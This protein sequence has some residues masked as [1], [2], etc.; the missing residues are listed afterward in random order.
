MKNYL[1]YLQSGGNTRNLK[2][3]FTKKPENEVAASDKETSSYI[4]WNIRKLLEKYGNKKTDVKTSEVTPAPTISN[5]SGRVVNL[6]ISP[7]HPRDAYTYG[8][9][10]YIAYHK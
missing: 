8:H 2:R 3:F 10:T 6:Y 9:T 1:E 7:E 4:L 5:N